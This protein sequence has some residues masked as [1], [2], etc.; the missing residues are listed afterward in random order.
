MNLWAMV[1]AAGRG[2]RLGGIRKALILIRDKPMVFHACLPLA[3]HP[4]LKGIVV[5]ASS[6]DVEEVKKQ[7]AALPGN[8]VHA[9]VRGGETRQESVAAALEAI[10]DKE[11]VVLV[12]D[13]ARPVLRRSLVDRIVQAPWEGASG[14]IPI[15]SIH[16][17]VRY[18]SE[19]KVVRSLDRR[20]LSAVQTPQKF[21][22][23]LLRRLW[24]EQKN[25]GVTDDAQLLESEGLALKTVAGD[26][27]NLKVTTEEDLALVRAL[28]SANLEP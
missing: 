25:A 8:K 9:V 21:P 20:G 17:T 16:D 11:G 22:L 15:V 18:V 2:M 12:H 3:R 10:P 24:S 26:P 4:D 7:L 1:P 19:G 5:A 14:V 28:L 6:E 23:E 27:A 13:G